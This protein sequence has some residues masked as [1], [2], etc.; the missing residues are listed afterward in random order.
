MAVASGSGRARTAVLVSPNKTMEYT[1]VVGQI[2]IGRE[3]TRVF[4]WWY[5]VTKKKMVAL[6]VV[7]L[8]VVLVTVAIVAVVFAVPEQYRVFLG[9]KSAELVRK[10]GGKTDRR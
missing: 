4:P 5:A 2:E 8:L 3:N 6:S 10:R 9:A 7:V 1:P